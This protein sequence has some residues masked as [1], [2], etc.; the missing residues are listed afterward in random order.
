[1]PRRPSSWWPV[2]HLALPAGL[3]RIDGQEADQRVGMRGDVLGDVA[4]STH[5][6]LSRALPPKT[7]VRVSPVAAL[8]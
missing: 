4:S 7:I 2:S 5:R 8:R 6:P 1:M 3:R